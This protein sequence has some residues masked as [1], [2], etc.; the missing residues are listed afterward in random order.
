MR[1]GQNEGKQGGKGLT[2]SGCEM[3]NFS[4]MTLVD[5]GVVIERACKYGRNACDACNACNVVIERR[6]EGKGCGGG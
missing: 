2:V 4:D 6:G 1:R 3:P 5:R